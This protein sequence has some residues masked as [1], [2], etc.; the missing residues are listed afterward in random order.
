MSEAFGEFWGFQVSYLAWTAGVIEAAVFPVLAYETLARPF[1]PDEG[2]PWLFDYLCR[3]CVRL[4]IY[5][6]S[7]IPYLS[8]LEIC[9]RLH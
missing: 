4:Y 8:G 2:F 9:T 5:V 3:V 6:S 7:F 1:K